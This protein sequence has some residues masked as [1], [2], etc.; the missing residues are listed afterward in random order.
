MIKIDKKRIN[1]L[2]I[3][4]VSIFCALSVRLYFL[5]VY[6]TERVEAQYKNHQTES[7]S[8]NKY[9]L[10]DT[11]GKDLMEYKKKYI[12]VIDTKP[13]KL[14]NYEETLEDLMALNFIMKGEDESFNYT[15]VIKNQGKLYYN[16]S[17]ETYNK[18]KK[19]NN[20]KGIYTFLS[21]K[22][23]KKEAWSVNGMFSNIDDKNLVKGSLQEEIYNNIKDNEI[24]KKNFYLDDK[25]VYSF[26]ELDVN[27][28]NKNIKLT[29]DKEIENKIRNVLSKEEYL[30]YN[31]VGVTIMESNT[32]KIRAMVQKDE[33]A[34]NINLGIEGLGYEPGSIFKLITYGAALENACTTQYNTVTCTGKMCERGSHG[35]ITVREGL[36]KSCNEVFGV[37][38]SKVGYKDLMEYSEKMGLFKRNLNI[39]G[40]GR[41]ET[42]GVKPAEDES[43]SLISIGQSMNTS[44][45]QM[46]G[47]VNTFVNNGVYVK[48]YILE[49]VQNS[50]DQTIKTYS[51]TKEKIF[52]E[53]TSKIVKNGMREVVLNGTGQS[54]NVNGIEIGGKTGSATTSNK[55]THGWFV[56]YFKV[57]NKEY[58][59]IVFIPDLVSKKN[60]SLGGGNTA[61]PIFKDIVLEL[62]K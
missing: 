17:E 13:F 61:A 42:E 26:E 2:R 20:I 51:T 46:L 8:D 4:L 16:I 50:E 49:E 54:A 30:N 38:G 48:P 18:I 1:A 55:T 39:Q 45:I 37:I 27:K 22:T 15:D 34:A 57:K 44:P 31:N 53:T 14:N 60:E 25:A 23:D 11:N 5:Q 35:T 62:N 33:S 40:E 56:G 29:V 58:T 32:G 12:L 43:M 24:P 28:N 59:M 47:A 41:N 10:L 36:I 21:D 52:T 19:L 6:P 9:M 3:A 7:I